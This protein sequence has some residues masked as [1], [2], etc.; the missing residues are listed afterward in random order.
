MKRPIYK[1]IF[2]LVFFM[3]FS[4]LLFACQEEDPILDTLEGYNEGIESIIEAGNYQVKVDNPLTDDEEDFVDS[5]ANGFLPIN[6][7]TVVFSNNDAVITHDIEDT[8]VYMESGNLIVDSTK[9]ITLV[10]SGT[11]EGSII[12]RKSDGKFKLVLNGV[13]ITSSS[14]PAINLQTEK[15]CFIVIADGTENFI[16]DGEDHPVM[17]NGSTTKGAIFSEEQIIISGEGK[18][19]VNGR[20]KHGIA[21]D[22]YIKIISGEIIIES[23]VSD[24]LRANDYVVID[25]GKIDIT[26]SGDGI[27]VERGY[28]VINGG[29]LNIDA[30]GD[31]IKAGNQ[32]EDLSIKPYISIFNGDIT[33]K[34]LD[35][36]IVSDDDINLYQGVIQSLTD[37]DSV[38]AKGLIQVMDGLYYFHSLE[39][40]TLD[41]D[42]GVHIL[43]GTLV[44]LSDGSEYALKSNEGALQLNGGTILIAG[45]LDVSIDEADQGYIKLGNIS[46]NEVIH[47]MRDGFN[48]YLGFINSYAHVIISSVDMIP[49]SSYQ[50]YSGGTH[51]GNNFYGFYVDG[52]YQNGTLKQE[53]T[54]LS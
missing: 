8:E 47:V 37:G 38:S 39:K 3:L 36:G 11:L 27:E 45:A 29:T 42:L 30:E 12:V 28:V 23:T 31:G 35:K 4:A 7:V 17:S 41:G 40:Q 14:G 54:A 48:L 49:A 9:K 53:V 2:I 51:N 43:G 33:I 44:L 15:R 46:Q 6:T 24:G 16:T 26:S 13:T 50:I 10:V 52:T 25:G 1:N 21:S 34:A 32:S 20:Y 22:D 5:S 18:L 19:V